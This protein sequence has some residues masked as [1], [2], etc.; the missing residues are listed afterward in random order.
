MKHLMALAALIVLS[1]AAFADIARPDPVKTPK[2]K[3]AAGY[4]TTMNVRVDRESK[5]ARLIIPKSQVKALR[6]E[7]DAIDAEDNTAAV[8]A[9]GGIS[10]TQTAMTGIFLSL[11]LVFGGMWIVR[12][13]KASSKNAKALIVGL[14]VAGIASAA[15]L[16][17]ANIGPPP[18]VRGITGK[19]FSESMRRYGVGSGQVRVE[20]STKEDRLTLIV[21]D[22][23]DTPAGE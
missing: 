2:A 6:A 13:G 23:V 19:M 21:P 7:L 18:T 15:T 17:Y 11:A 3:P 9:P 16:A 14:T 1:T 12:S 8:T 22:T 4:L 20:T 10:R 5:E